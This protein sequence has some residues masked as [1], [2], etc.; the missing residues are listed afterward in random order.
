MGTLQD[1]DDGLVF[2]LSVDGTHC[3]IEEP[4]PFSTEWSSHKF[5]GKPAVNYEL[6]ILIHKPKLVWV[7]GPTRPG[8]HNDLAVFRQKLKQALSAL[9]GTKKAIGDSGYRG[10]PELISTRNGLDS[11]E[12]TQFKDRTLARHENFN[13][14]LKCFACLCQPFRHGVDNHGYAFKACCVLVM[15]EVETGGTSFSDAYP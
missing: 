10:E 15:Y 8:K 7:N 5:G 11:K 12:V 9:P 1:N 4:R 2:M 14:R 6:G 3:P 13:Q